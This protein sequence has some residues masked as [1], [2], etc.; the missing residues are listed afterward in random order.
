MTL[1]LEIGGAPSSGKS[2]L[3]AGLYSK[4]SEEGYSVQ[5]V[6]EYAT[7]FNARNG[8]IQPY[9]HVSILGKQMARMQA[10]LGKVDILISDSPLYLN[11]FYSGMVDQKSLTLEC[12]EKIYDQLQC[13]HKIKQIFLC[14]LQNKKAAGRI[15]EKSK[16]IDESL[17]LF[18]AREFLYFFKE[19]H[20]ESSENFKER[21]ENALK[22]VK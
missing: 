12:V 6:R 8:S 17:R 11:S 3:A 13:R 2:T 15:H 10:F 1:I 22:M 5:L 20:N 18:F 7:E 14:P 21:L 4:L 19:S 9:E 16:E